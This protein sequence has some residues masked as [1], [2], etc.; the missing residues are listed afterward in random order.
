[1]N[2]KYINLQTISIP[3]CIVAIKGFIYKAKILKCLC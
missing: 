2:I 3:I 1:M